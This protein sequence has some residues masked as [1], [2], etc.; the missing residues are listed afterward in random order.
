MSD[1]QAFRAIYETHHAAVCAYF[2]R[3]APRDEVED[4]AAETFTVAW[5][6]L[7]RRVE[8]PLPWL[9][10]VAGK[11][12]ANH[13]RKAARKGAL[14]PDPSN[15]D[16]AERFGG[17]RGLA[18]AFATLSERDREAI[19]LVAWEGLSPADAARAADCSEATFA[20]RL[21][22]A[23]KKLALQLDP[24]PAATFIVPE[25]I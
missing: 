18:E 5:R 25:R 23:R 10:A 24:P 21:S 2:A 16:P 12:L 8:H 13:R 3:R 1:P 20:V 9:Y 14:A 17:D 15:G 22:R 4:L 6:K 11:V 19:C 7:P